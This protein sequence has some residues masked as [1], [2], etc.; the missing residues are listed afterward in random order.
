VHVLTVLQKNITMKIIFRLLLS[1]FVMSQCFADYAVMQQRAT[2]QQI[3][4]LINFD[5]EITVYS[6]NPDINDGES[7]FRGY[8]ITASAGVNNKIDRKNLLTALAQSTRESNGDPFACFIPRHGISFIKD[9]MRKDIVICF[10]C[11][12][13][14]SYGFE[15]S[16]IIHTST[17]QGVFDAFLALNDNKPDK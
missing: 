17:A 7:L 2:A 3:E 8:L 9:G 11:N 5:G 15:F 6:L 13:S 16:R 12:S 1:L 14:L 4:E 10:E